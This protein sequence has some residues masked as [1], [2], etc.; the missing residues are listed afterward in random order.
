M[1]TGASSCGPCRRSRSS[2]I[3]HPASECGN[4][5]RSST[6]PASSITVTSWP[7]LAQSNPTYFTSSLPL[8]LVVDS[9][10]SRPSPVPHCSAL[11]RGMSLTPVSGPRRIGGGS[12]KTGRLPAR[13]RGHPPTRPRSHSRYRFRP[14][15]EYFPNEASDDFGLRQAFVGAA[16]GVGAGAWVVAEAAKNDNVERVVG[17]TVA[18]AIEP[19]AVGASAAGGDRRG[20]AEVREG[21]FGLDPVKL[22][23]ALMSTWPAT[24]GPTPG[25]ASRAGAACCTS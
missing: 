1:I 8:K 5:H 2:V 18:A 22:S 25:R 3:T 12:T 15:L 20:A 23:P 19:V 21:G 14:H 17:A 16:L 10:V 6:R 11:G 9:T 7:W 24:S 13:Q 4:A